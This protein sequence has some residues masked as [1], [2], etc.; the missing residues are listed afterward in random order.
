MKSSIVLACLVILVLVL[1]SC[2]PGPNELAGTPDAKGTVAG[3]WYGLWHGIISPVTFIISLFNK[4]VQLYD[5]HNNGG[6]Y[7]FGFILGL[8]IVFSGSAGGAASR[9]RRV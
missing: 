9:R 6:W 4:A 7:N 1:A 3:F 5:A 2:A 8:S